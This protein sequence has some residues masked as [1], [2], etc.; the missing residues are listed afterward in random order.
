VLESIRDPLSLRKFLS[1]VMHSYDYTKYRIDRV[2]KY[3][4]SR[5]GLDEPELPSAPY[6]G[7]PAT[8]P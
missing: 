6:T 4:L 7:M 5:C 8:G 2:P 3:E 1:N